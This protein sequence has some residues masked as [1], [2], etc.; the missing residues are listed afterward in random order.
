MTVMLRQT[1]HVGL[2]VVLTL[3]A[4]GLAAPGTTT[5][6]SSSADGAEFDRITADIRAAVERHDA[7]AA[8][9]YE[10]QLDRLIVRATGR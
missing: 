4:A 9:L 1:R 7:R 5:A 2:L 3:A 6:A 10:A 8:H